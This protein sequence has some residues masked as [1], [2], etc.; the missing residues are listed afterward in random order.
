[1]DLV[2]TKCKKTGKSI[3]EYINAIMQKTQQTTKYMKQ[4]R[5]EVKIKRVRVKHRKNVH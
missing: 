5:N 3:A 2:K 4:V 1:M